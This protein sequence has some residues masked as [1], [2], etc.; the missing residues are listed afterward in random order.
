MELKLSVTAP[1]PKVAKSGTRVKTKK[2]NFDLFKFMTT[3]R[4]WLYVKRLDVLGTGSSR[5]VYIVNNKL[6]IKMAYAGY[7]CRGN[8]LPIGAGK[9]QNKVEAMV[10]ADPMSNGLVAKVYAAAPDYRW[11]IVENCDEGSDQDDDDFD[12]KAFEK[13][14]QKY[15]LRDD[16]DVLGINSDKKLVMLDYG[17]DGDVY[18]DYY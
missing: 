10:S 14:S 11:I 3:K 4:P 13:L 12:W 15:D 16:D 5:I 6:V 18:N 9:T 2:S 17:L 1:S 7:E 8:I